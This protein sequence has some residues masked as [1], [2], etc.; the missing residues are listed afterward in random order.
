[1]TLKFVVN[2]INETEDILE[3]KK[4]LYL[5]FL[6]FN[7]FK[8]VC[9]F[10][11]KNKI[12][13][14]KLMSFSKGQNIDTF[15]IDRI[16]PFLNECRSLS[17]KKLKS[18]YCISYYEAKFGCSKEDAASMLSNFKKDKSTSLEGFIKRHGEE[19]GREKF[20]AFQK[21]SSFT[22][23][24]ERFKGLY[25]E[26]WKEEKDKFHKE[27]SS[28]SKDHWIKK[29]HTEE[30]AIKIVSE[31]QLKNSGLFRTFWKN[32]G[33]SES[34]I[35]NLFLVINAKK[36]KH[37]R[38]M[39]FMK[40]KYGDGWEKEWMAVIDKI[41]LGME[42]KGQWVKKSELKHF[43]QYKSEVWLYTELSIFEN[44]LKG[45][46]KR[47][48]DFH[49]DHIFSLKAGYINRISPKIIGSICNLRILDKSSNCKKKDKCDIDEHSLLIKY[50][51]F[52]RERIASQTKY[53]DFAL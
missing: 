3:Y 22:Y 46:E 43:N 32:K 15:F 31:R 47:S 12:S 45:I 40:E 41:R 52:E 20:S 19:V 13:S 8:N 9:L 35:N 10:C 33:L 30:E 16:I 6:S 21:T 29:G 2:S 4:F 48:K 1:M 36:G 17:S 50:R 44:G 51:I 11:I 25:G 42:L 26:N 23:S 49:V 14:R 5:S 7:S 24:E 38:S 53:H 18:F 34:E 39:S 27:S 28:A 37:N